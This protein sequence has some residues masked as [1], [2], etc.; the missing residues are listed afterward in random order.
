MLLCSN[1]IGK[2][3]SSKIAEVVL[4]HMKNAICK[5]LGPFGSP[6][7]EAVDNANVLITKDGYHIIRNVNYNDP[8]AMTFSQIIKDLSKELVSS[9]GDGST[10]CIVA[11]YHFFMKLKEEME[12]G[13]LK[14]VRQ[15]EIMDSINHVVEL[16]I[17]EIRKLSIP[18]SE[19]LEEIKALASVS[20]NNNVEMGEMIADIYKKIGTEGYINVE[21]GN[22]PLTY[23]DETDG[24]MINFGRMDEIF[25]NNDYNESEL[26]DTCVLIF[27]CAI[28]SE[29][30]EK[31]V[32]E[33]LNNI[34][35]M[36]QLPNSQYKSLLI[37]TPG[38]GMSMINKMRKFVNMYSNKG[39]KLNFNII[40]YSTATEFDRS[41]LYDIAIMC[42]AHVI[43]E[44]EKEEG[45]LTVSFDK[46]PEGSEE[47]SSLGDYMGYA[48]R[49]VSGKRTTTFYGGAELE[50][51]INIEK[52]K[53]L[54]EL[55]Q[56]ESD[57]R[58]LV[59]RYELR[60]RLATLAKKIVTIYVGGYNE[61][62]RKS[63]KELID[64][65]VNACR[66][67][68]NNGYVVGGNLV[69]N[70]AVEIIK[71]QEYA[72]TIELN[73]TH[74]CILEIISESFLDVLRDVLGNKFDLGNDMDAAIVNNIVKTCKETYTMYD[75]IK[76]ECTATEIINPA[77]TDIEIL[78][79]ATSIISLILTSNQFITR[80]A[81]ELIAEIE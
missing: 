53:I 55:K 16:I 27:N 9:V 60:K 51:E 74:I 40:Q 10:S 20:L 24:F 11:A 12:K 21:L 81:N 3:R 38:I 62:N 50:N 34:N 6:T 28:N 13:R 22:G 75:L 77:D 23:T 57:E 54:S 78:K 47:K 80:N 49:I 48:K 1:I 29:T 43:T 26:N 58:E 70:R 79:H 52:N 31:Y 8:V 76:G 18:V 44:T 5:S 66:S 59:R 36:M 15:K 35:R 33:T 69:I 56:I 46:S 72:E 45:D 61:A 39:A 67:A 65:A 7:I 37:I 25:V 2:E 68:I 73:D 19:N 71:C 42:G 41:M 14:G 4:E 64:D 63:D 30:Q 17:T 32:I